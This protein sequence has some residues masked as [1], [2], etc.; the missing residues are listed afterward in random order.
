MNALIQELMKNTTVHGELSGDERA[1]LDKVGKK[2]CEVRQETCWMDANIEQ[3]C[4]FFGGKTYRIK[5]AYQPEPEEEALCS[6]MSP[7]QIQTYIDQR[8]LKM[9]PVDH[10]ISLVLIANLAARLSEIIEEQ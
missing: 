5:V 1:C 10:R 3:L 2:N 8:L 7:K 4:S 9:H 6:D